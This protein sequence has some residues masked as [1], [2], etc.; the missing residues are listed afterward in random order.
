MVSTPARA[1]EA[2]TDPVP[3]ALVAVSA[4]ADVGDDSVEH[5]GGTSSALA[6]TTPAIR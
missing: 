2:S 6:I 1:V 3:G 5:P 4:S